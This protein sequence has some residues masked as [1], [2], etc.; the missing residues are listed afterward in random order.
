M[1][2]RHTLMVCLW[3]GLASVR[4][5]PLL[6]REELRKIPLNDAVVINPVG[7]W[8]LSHPVNRPGHTNQSGIVQEDGRARF[9]VAEANT[10]AG[11]GR[12]LPTIVEVDRYPVLILTYRATGL[13]PSEEALLGLRFEKGPRVV[14]LRNSDLVCDGTVR[15][16]LVTLDTLEDRGPVTHIG[17]HP[18]CQGP[19]PAVFEVLGIRFEGDGDLPPQA[20]AE[21][22]THTVRIVDTA[23]Q[24]LAGVSVITDAEILNLARS[25]ETDANGRAT[26]RVGESPADGH[27]IQLQK[28]GMG[29]VKFVVP[30]GKPFP[31]II[32]MP[33]GIRYGGIVHD[34]KGEPVPFA[35][36]EVSTRPRQLAE[37][38]RGRTRAD[39]LADAEGRW[40]TPILWA[41]GKPL[42]RQ[43]SAHPYHSGYYHGDRTSVPAADD[44]AMRQIEL[45]L[46]RGVKLAGRVVGPAGQP[47]SGVEL[48]LARRWHESHPGQAVTGVTGGFAF[49]QWA[50]DDRILLVRAE[51]FAAQAL[52]VYLVPGMEEQVVRLTADSMI[53][54]RVVD[55][56]GGPLA[57]VEV[58]AEC[59][60]NFR[61]GLWEGIT[62]ADGQFVW[63][64]APEGAVFF[65]FEDGEHMALRRFPLEATEE[66]QTVVMPS[67]VRLHG[68]IT[69]AETGKPVENCTLTPGSTYTPEG[70]TKPRAPSYWR[71]K[72]SWQVESG[73]YETRLN[74]SAPRKTMCLRVQ[75]DGYL[76]SIVTAPDPVNPTGNRVDVRLRR[77]EGLHGAV[78]LRDG[79]P[80]AWARLYLVAPRENLWF[81]KGMRDPRLPKERVARTD[82]D[83]NYQ[84][85]ASVGRGY[86][87]VVHRDGY[88]ETD[89]RQTKEKLDL[90]LT[91]WGRLTGT[92]MIGNQAA[93]HCSVALSPEP[94]PPDS[95][96]PQIR[97]FGLGMQTNARGRFRFDWVP[98]GHGM[99]SG[100][101]YHSPSHSSGRLFSRQM[102]Y[103][104]APRE[105]TQVVLGGTGRPVTGK[106][107]LPK[108][109]RPSFGW[110]M[111]MGM[112]TADDSS[113]YH[114]P[115]EKDGAFRIEDI[116]SGLYELR[117]DFR[118]L[119]PGD[120]SAEHPLLGEAT[121]S[122]TIPKM[123]DGRS[124]KPLDLGTLAVR[125]EK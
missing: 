94:P 36:V 111:G 120:R 84:F 53:W 85:A 42:E 40:L 70:G 121:H 91:P 18:H 93:R 14:P 119:V 122:F 72:S 81:G 25:T 123:A 73:R 32:A 50:R 45:V 82:V 12:G 1:S 20:L 51:G 9:V 75:A 87:I 39:V 107:V 19:A 66:T 56:A 125:V 62:D 96:R 64:A 22:T 78:R 6:D 92:F 49:S 60:R 2:M 27:T 117:I 30:E 102:D 71:E 55:S 118:S 124:D 17:L 101:R 115:I 88:L 33:R 95:D 110:R 105:T 67:A 97:S 54:G 5:Q 69:D 58:K 4:A 28:E 59:W 15:E 68:T 74:G 43:I 34:E 98:P 10:Q 29:V 109:K 79:K 65:R 116:P 23:G 46:R 99:I 44:A 80:A 63:E 76:P 103:T 13:K 24:S 106:L 16:A 100:P 31:A 37:G 104:V 38:Y 48:Q 61:K 108:G 114:F 52:H 7:N 113:V 89:A 21:E 35:G 77:G 8:A 11:W 90:E 57:G 3:A 112:L 47:V 83:G 41:E 26:V 86:L